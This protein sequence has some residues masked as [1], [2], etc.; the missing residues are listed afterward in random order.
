PSPSPVARCSNVNVIK[1][2]DTERAFKAASYSAYGATVSRYNF[3]VTNESGTVVSNK[4]YASTV[5]SYTSPAISLSPGNYSVKAIVTTSLGDKTSSD[6][7]QSFSVASP[8]LSI[9]KT[10][11]ET[12]KIS[13]NLNDT[14]TYK[15][16]VKN[17]GGTTLSQLSVTDEAPNGIDFIESTAGD[18]TDTTWSATIDSLA[19]N[20]S[21]IYSITAKASERFDA[22][23]TLAKNVACVSTSV[24]NGSTLEDCDGALV[25]MPETIMSV[26]EFSTDSITTIKKSQFD[27]NL[28]S[29][30]PLACE[31]IQVCDTTSNT[32]VTIRTPDFNATTQTKDLS[33]CDDMQVC[34]LTSGD[35]IIIKKHE[36]TD[37]KYSEDASD[38]V[39]SIAEAKTALNISQNSVDATKVVAQPSDRIRYKLT[40]TNV[41]SVDATSDFTEDLQDVLEYARVIDTGGGSFNESTKTLS[42]PSIVLEPGESQTRLFTIELAETIPAAARGISNP[43]SF[44]CTMLNTYGN[45]VTIDVSCPTSK[46]VEQTVS[47]LPQTGPTENILFGAAL[48]S[49]VVYFYARSRQLGKEVRLIRRDINAG[50][51]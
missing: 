20:A 26:C 7:Q 3:V 2:S 24:I 27:E 8:G 40:A 35:V 33:D 1:T 22:G 46:L 16:V 25:D 37:E 41:G 23:S 50:T 42:W 10:V 5:E 51:I 30:D 17:T 38:C 15:I 45:T 39:P 21:R 29:T 6:C 32:V 36:F 48:I 44:D 13:V 31:K 19:P 34:D 14:F 9:E 18:S 28:Y 47:E 4:S 11:N 12:E 49:L 43:T